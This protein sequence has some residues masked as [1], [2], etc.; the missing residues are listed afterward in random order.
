[1][2]RFTAALALSS[3]A[4]T[5]CVATDNQD[6]ITIGFAGNLRSLDPVSFY[7]PQE[8]VIGHN[9]FPMLVNSTPD[10][11]EFVGDVAEEFSFI[12][13]RVF[14]ATVKEGLVFANGNTLDASDVAFSLNRQMS[15]QDPA[16]P[17]GLLDIV[18]N[19]TAPD[20]MTVRIETNLDYPST[21]L[22]ILS[23]YP[24]QIVD[25][26]VFPADTVLSNEEVLD[27]GAFAGP[28]K[29]ESHAFPEFITFRANPD[30]QGPFP[31]GNNELVTLRMFS[32]STNAVLALQSGEIDFMNVYRTLTA[33]DTAAL[34]D[35]DEFD[36]QLGSQVDP[37]YVV[38]D[39]D[40]GP[41]G[42]NDGNDP[43]KAKAVRNAVAHLIDREQITEEIYL[44]FASPAYS[45]VPTEIAGHFDAFTGL[46]GDGS[47]GPSLEAAQEE[48]DAAGITEVIELKFAY[49]V[50]RFGP[51]LPDAVAMIKN[52][53]EASGLFSVELIADE[54]QSLKERGRNGEFDLI[55]RQW[56]PDYPDADNFV[57][58]LI[59]VASVG[60]DQ[61][62]LDPLQESQKTIEDQAERMLVLEELQT[63]IAE[64]LVIIPI[65]YFGQ[66][67]LTVE[68]L[69]GVDKALAKNFKFQFSY[70]SKN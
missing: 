53:L 13:P 17:W 4:L 14:E 32:D 55:W 22:A 45:S 33:S 6:Q 16:G 9:L 49:S 1:M 56:G 19:V 5:G 62:E 34:A 27:S 20:P 11:D 8:F 64:D 37:G 66:G 39:H 43:E 26:E 23:S 52:Q 67:A 30:Y 51:N 63:K 41:F 68:G 42:I 38:V 35:S 21:L 36:F 44:G 48:F 46:Y 28:Y 40:N 18:D 12:E 54:H 60:Y 47:G 2:K 25:E 50:G 29:V 69:T 7:S 57:A 65:A 61:T 31:K 24:G 10:G 59:D 15:I 70:L 3:L 58:T